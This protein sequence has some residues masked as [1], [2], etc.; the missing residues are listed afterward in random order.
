MQ[1]LLKLPSSE[2]QLQA[3]NF[4]GDLAMAI[5]IFPKG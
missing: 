4:S 2:F 5:F 3:I 1:G